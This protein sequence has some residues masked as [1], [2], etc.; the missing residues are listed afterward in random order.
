MAYTVLAVQELIIYGP[1][2]Q[3]LISFYFIYIPSAAPLTTR[4]SL[5]DVKTTLSVWLDILIYFI[6]STVL[7]IMIIPGR[8]I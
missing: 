1:A 5:S 7:T 8:V 4:D 2:T 6:F 3:G